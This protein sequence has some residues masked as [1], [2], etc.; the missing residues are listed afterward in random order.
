MWNVKSDIWK[1]LFYQHPSD[2]NI[3]STDILRNA[4]HIQ[5]IQAIWWK[6]KVFFLFE[7]EWYGVTCKWYL[8]ANGFQWNVLIEHAS[9][10]R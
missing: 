1:A 5:T 3:Q 9:L 6:S 10:H 2:G 7:H 8:H 4:Q